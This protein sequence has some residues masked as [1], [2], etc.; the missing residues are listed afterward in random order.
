MRSG[1]KISEQTYS[2]PCR[3]DIARHSGSDQNPA[4]N[5][6]SYSRKSYCHFEKI[7]LRVF[8]RNEGVLCGFRLKIGRL[9]AEIPLLNAKTQHLVLAQNL[10]Y[11]Y[12]LTD[13]LWSIHMGRLLQNKY[14]PDECSK[15]IEP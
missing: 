8:Q 9:S 15:G 3:A 13:K 6:F 4:N 10:H 12:V 7:N 14:A 5:S 11:L 1:R 2:F